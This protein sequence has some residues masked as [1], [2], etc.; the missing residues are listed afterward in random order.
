MSETTSNP[1]TPEVENTAP[2]SESPTPEGREAEGQDEKDEQK[3]TDW[4]GMAVGLQATLAEKNRRLEE[5]ERERQELAQRTQAAQPSPTA[6]PRM[7]QAQADMARLQQAYYSVS[8]RA[9]AGDDDALLMLK[10]IE[11]QM[12]TK[13]ATMQQ[14]ELMRVADPE[15]REKVR[16]FFEANRHKYA[17]VEAAEEAFD[18][19][20]FR[21]QRADLERKSKE[22]EAILKAKES[23]LTGT[24]ASREVT[25]T[26]MKVRKMT[27]EQFDNEV[28]RLR[29]EGKHA[30]ARNLMAQVRARKVLLT[31]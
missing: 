21:R 20:E 29:Q 6:D 11:D 7:A 14:L 5:L 19:L 4:R 18:G 27:P 9:A 31:G 3:R 12:Q 1:G 26:E 15:R 13:N 23:G 17:S 28:E 2:T 25:A 10:V 24:H 16:V 22:A 30:E 8:Q